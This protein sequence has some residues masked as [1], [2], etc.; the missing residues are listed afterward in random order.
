MGPELLVK[1][2]FFF[3]IVCNIYKVP[4]IESGICPGHLLRRPVGKLSNEMFFMGFLKTSL[5]ISVTNCWG[6]IFLKNSCPILITLMIVAN[7]NS[8]SIDIEPIY[9]FLIYLPENKVIKCDLCSGDVISFIVFMLTFLQSNPLNV[10]SRWET[11]CAV[12][13]TSD[14][15]VPLRHLITGFAIHIRYISILCYSDNDNRGSCK[16]V[17]MP[18]SLIATSENRLTCGGA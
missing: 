15:N 11:W 8:L 1:W 2:F 3:I 18:I 16:I 17:L 14:Q 6:I 13:K 7:C 12:T 10:L 9:L 5:V 4:S